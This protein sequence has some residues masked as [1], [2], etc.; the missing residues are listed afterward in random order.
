MG[1]VREQLRCWEGYQPA[2]APTCLCGA[3]PVHFAEAAVGR[4]AICLGC[5]RAW[6]W[7]KSEEAFASLL[8]AQ[9]FKRKQQ[10][11]RAGGN[12]R[13]LYAALSLDEHL[14]AVWRAGQE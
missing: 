7:S 12:C 10:A 11:L 8:A 4:A 13:S 6:Y 9:G 14:S 1:T 3:P 2:P 5:L